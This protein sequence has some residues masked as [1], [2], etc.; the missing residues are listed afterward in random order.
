MKKIF[1]L[2]SVLSILSIPAFASDEAVVTS[3]ESETAEATQ[4]AET[5]RALNDFTDFSHWSLSLN[6]GMSQ[7]DGDV[8]Q[9]YDQILSNS[10][11]SWT[12]G[13]EAEY[14]WN[15]A[16]GLI[17]NFQ[18]MP[19]QGKTSSTEWGRNEFKGNMYAPSLLAS[20]NMFNLFSQYR[21]SAAWNLYLNAGVGLVWYECFN[22]PIEGSAPGEKTPQGIGQDGSGYGTSISIPLGLNVEYN[23]NK[24]LAVGLGAYYRVTNKDNFEGEHYTKGTMNDGQFYVNANLRVK[25][26]DD[27]KVGGHMRNISMNEYRQ[28]V[29]GEAGLI[30]DIDSLK[31][32]VKV[33]EDTVAN[34]ILPRIQALEDYNAVT[35]D[36]DGDG[37]ADFRD[38]EPNTPRGAFVNYWGESIPQEAIGCCDEVKEVFSA[39]GI[40]PSV[41]YDQSVYYAFDKYAVTS[42]A[43]KNIESVVAQ[44]NADPEL[45][46]E[47][48]GYCD[49]PGSNDY[50]LK[51]SQKRVEA[52]K[53]EL[54]KAGIDES[55]ITTTPQGKLPN[56]PKAE[57]KNRR[58]DFFFSK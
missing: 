12:I 51:L 13:L 16:W 2:L 58:C 6:V 10:M 36:E 34:N 41:N 28:L 37:V 9:K 14:S 45:K 42:K 39:L 23:I 48:R 49:F 54:L 52:V 31:K 26:L 35:P 46:V 40:D 17:L 19:Y 4:A 56:P 1:A 20:V 11:V 53:A 25:F 22:N 57:Q 47:I 8:S 32:R 3:L 21:K 30:Q 50:N 7:F 24:Y 44:L 5:P 27:N 18:Y 15:P 55:R 43:K 33:L 29:T 38:R